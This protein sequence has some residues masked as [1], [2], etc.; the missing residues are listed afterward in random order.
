M[1][2]DNQLIFEIKSQFLCPYCGLIGCDF[3]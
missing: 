1:F 3:A 2:N